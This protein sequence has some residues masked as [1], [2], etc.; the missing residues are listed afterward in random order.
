MSDGA[1]GLFDMPRQPF[2]K[3]PN[4]RKNLDAPGKWKMG[5][6]TRRLR[7]QHI[8]KIGECL[9]QWPDVDTQLALLLASL[10]RAN[11]DAMVAVYAALRRSTPRVEAIKAAASV[12]LDKRGQA[13][14]E[15]I[16]RF[17]ERV[18]VG[19]N[20]LAHGH[21]GVSDFIPEGILWMHGITTIDFHVKH[22]QTE[23]INGQPFRAN[24]QSDIF[25][26]RL[27]DFDEISRNISLLCEVIFEF[28]TYFD[29][30]HRD[31]NGPV[32]DAI[33]ARLESYVPIRQALSHLADYVFQ[34]TPPKPKP[35]SRK[36][37]QE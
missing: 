13:L 20:A 14:V 26:Y 21:W 24:I 28:R 17:V 34:P 27:K 16:I 4:I 5:T 19:R 37:S 7:P 31:D 29:G 25:Y 35:R 12:S 10:T 15:A 3:H 8:A 32:S 36:P 9:T 23:I 2:L 18:E 6:A 22:R 33:C 1:E 11:A 30:F